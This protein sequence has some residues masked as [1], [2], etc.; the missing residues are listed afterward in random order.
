MISELYNQYFLYNG[1]AFQMKVENKVKNTQEKN[2][3]NKPDVILTQ[4]F[5]L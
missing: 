4:H 2:E 5:D 3:Y 1:F